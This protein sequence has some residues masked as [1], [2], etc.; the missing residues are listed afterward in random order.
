MAEQPQRDED[1]KSRLIAELERSRTGLAH[2][3]HGVRGSLDVG[4]HLRRSVLR[5]KT[6]WF[7]GA[8]MTGWL[9]TRL[10]RLPFRKKKE[11][12]ADGGAGMHLLARWL[13]KPKES[14][15]GGWLLATL[16]LAGTLLKPALTAFLSRKLADFAGRNHEP[17]GRSRP[18][19][20]RPRP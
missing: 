8:A 12:K 17:E 3:L 5:Q 9:L 2:G 15:R 10:P 19:R 11:S 14:A 20:P 13:P 4:A 18:A 6:L 1:R 7:S 16:G